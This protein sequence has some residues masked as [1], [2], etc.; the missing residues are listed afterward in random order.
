VGGA[1]DISA[2]NGLIVSFMILKERSPLPLF[3]GV[4]L[5]ISD[6]PV[7][8]STHASLNLTQFLNQTPRVSCTRE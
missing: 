1:L 2:P 8:L 7:D 3:K 5:E 4:F 6:L